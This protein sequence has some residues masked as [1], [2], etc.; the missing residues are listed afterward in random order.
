MDVLRVIKGINILNVLVDNLSYTMII[1]QWLSDFPK[2]P[3]SGLNIS[4]AN[5][6][7]LWLKQSKTK[8][9]LCFSSRGLHILA[10]FS[11]VQRQH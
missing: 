4:E 1:C 6:V 8:Q 2:I 9:E 11:T 3:F 7:H 10:S 5:L